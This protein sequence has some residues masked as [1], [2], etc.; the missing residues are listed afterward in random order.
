MK[1]KKITGKVK[2][3]EENVKAEGNYTCLHDCIDYKYTGSTAAKN[4]G[5]KASVSA[6]YTR[7]L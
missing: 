1:V 4:C 5:R 6:K 3:G 7:V 2:L